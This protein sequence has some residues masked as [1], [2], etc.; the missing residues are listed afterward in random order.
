MKQDLVNFINTSWDTSII[1]ALEDYIRIPNKSPNF[2]PDWEA[3]GYMD[4]A[5]ELMVN[6]CKQQTVK[7][8][9]ISVEKLEGRTPSDLH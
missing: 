6:W 1:P 3:H 7:G 5:V 9:Q 2:D 8:M 4:Q